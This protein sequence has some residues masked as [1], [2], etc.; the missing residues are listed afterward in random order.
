MAAKQTRMTRKRR[1]SAPLDQTALRDLALSYV[2]RFSTTQAKLADYLRRKIRERGI[3][4]DADSLD[5]EAVVERLVELGYVDDAAFAQARSA[6]LLRKGYGGRRVDQA[7]RAAGIEESTRGHFAPDEV[8]ARRSA[9][10][11]AKK[12]G[13]GPFGRDFGPEGG[14]DLGKREKQI[15]A[16]VRAGHD[17]SSAKAMVDAVSTE[18]AEQWAEEAEEWLDEH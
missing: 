1:N 10:L 15:A 5:V 16:M 7:L 9:L 3:A 12:R 2:A 4:E 11:L 18:E 8:R 6:S 14:I 17:F 13:F